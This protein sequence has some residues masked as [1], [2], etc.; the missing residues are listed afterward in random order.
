[1]FIK[2][3]HF[4]SVITAIYITV[5]NFILCTVITMTRHPKCQQ[6][7]TSHTTH[8]FALSR[9][10]RFT[11]EG[12]ITPACFCQSGTWSQHKHRTRGQSYKILQLLTHCKLPPFKPPPSKANERTMKSR[13][14]ASAGLLPPLNCTA[15]T[16]L[17]AISRRPLGYF[18]KTPVVI[19]W[20][21]G[22]K[23]HGQAGMGGR[24]RCRF[25]KQPITRSAWQQ[26][27]NVV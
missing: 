21:K 9:G 25:R 17:S 20:C 10:R 5:I 2:R 7:P 4:S 13:Q 1:M 11:S 12:R 22:G 19:E 18:K 16:G 24:S 15:A 8:S 23:K 26:P 14:V 6:D 27:P 3:K